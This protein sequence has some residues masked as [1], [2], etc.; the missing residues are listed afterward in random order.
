M[1][2]GVEEFKFCISFIIL[3]HLKSIS[4]MVDDFKLV[5]DGRVGNCQFIKIIFFIDM[6]QP[7]GWINNNAEFVSCHTRMS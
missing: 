6:R 4:N 5:Y 7:T 3:F 2:F 1:V